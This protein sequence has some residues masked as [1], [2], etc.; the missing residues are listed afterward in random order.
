MRLLRC[1]FT[2]EAGGLLRVLF[3]RR[4]GLSADSS[5]GKL[6]WLEVLWGCEQRAGEHQF[7]VG[8]DGFGLERR[9]VQ[10]FRVVDQP[11]AALWRDQFGDLGDVLAGLVGGDDIT[12]G[13]DTQGLDLWGRGL[14]WSMK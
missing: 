14:E 7:P 1:G 4:C 10:S 13:A 9:N 12:G 11:E 8:R 3:L 2:P 6:L 5:R